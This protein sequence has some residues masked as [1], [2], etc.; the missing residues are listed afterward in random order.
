MHNSAVGFIGAGN[1]A[2]A[3]IGGIRRCG[4]Y[5][6][7]ALT[8]YD[9]NAQ[10]LQEMAALGL[11]TAGGAGQVVRDCGMVFLAVKPQNFQEVL[12]DVRP[13]VRADTLFVTIAAGISTAY[14]RERTVPDCKVVRAMPNTP[15]LL[16]EGATALCRT[17][18]VTDDEFTA[19]RRIFEA[20]GLVEVLTEDRMNE[21]IAVNGSSPAYVYLFAKTL[22]DRA[23][24]Y[25]IGGEAALR[26][27][28]QTLIGSAKMLLDSGKTPEELIR[29]VS[30][31]GGTTLAALEALE[32]GNFSGILRSAMDRCTKRAEELGR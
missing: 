15:L 4:L 7:R 1:M 16:G 5:P 9:V 24:E 3:I 19:V 27:V 20:S 29:M 26:L 14:I 10:K 6:S 28:A 2:S 32:E 8:V 31:P 17:G 11:Q 12:E 23:A 18:N 21:V 25:G 22:A 30:S 13:E